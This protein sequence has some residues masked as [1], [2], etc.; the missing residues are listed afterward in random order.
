QGYSAEEI[1]EKLSRTSISGIWDF[2]YS[3]RCTQFPQGYGN[4]F[5]KVDVSYNSY[6]TSAFGIVDGTISGTTNIGS[7][8]TVKTEDTFTSA[9][10]I[11]TYHFSRNSL[12]TSP[13][14]C[15]TT[16]GLITNLTFN[17]N[18]CL[19]LA[20]SC[21]SIDDYS[22]FVALGDVTQN[23]YVDN[24]DYVLLCNFLVGSS[25]AVITSAGLKAADANSDGNVDSTDAMLID[26]YLAHVN[27]HVWG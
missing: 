12:N 23:G 6:N 16:R 4:G 21:I 1:N 3:V 5:V 25:S 10:R 11:M 2:A 7:T 24:N 20:D 9:G 14:N 22:D 17:G 19:Y 18:N 15:I 8:V 27:N 26:L 13:S